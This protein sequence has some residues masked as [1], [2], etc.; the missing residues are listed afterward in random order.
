MCVTYVVRL[1]KHSNRK[2]DH[3][4]ASMLARNVLARNLQQLLHV[5][6]QTR[7]INIPETAPAM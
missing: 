6:S 3:K 2:R 1:D 7:G 5:S 4:V